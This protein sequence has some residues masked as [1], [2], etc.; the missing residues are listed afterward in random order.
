MKKFLY[1]SAASVAFFGL[2]VQSAS[3][4][5]FVWRDQASKM[6]VSYPDTWRHANNQ[7]PND[8]LT[9]LASGPNDFAQCVVNIQE[10]GRFKVY[11]VGLSAPIQRLYVSA[12]YWDEYLARYDNPVLHDGYDNRGLGDGNASMVSVSYTTAKGAKMQRRALGF[13]SYFDNR[14]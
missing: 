2:A 3:A 8:R 7:N 6:T 13:A 10:E 4:E 5:V 12:E 1:F 11:P 9:V 14:L